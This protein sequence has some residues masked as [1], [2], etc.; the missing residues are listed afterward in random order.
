MGFQL[1][2]E[3]APVRFCGP[4]AAVMAPPL[5][6]RSPASFWKTRMALGCSGVSARHGRDRGAARESTLPARCASRQSNCRRDFCI[7]RAAIH[8]PKASCLLRQPARM[9]RREP[10]RPADLPRSVHRPYRPDWP[11]VEPSP[12]DVTPTPVTLS[13]RPPAQPASRLMLSASPTNAGRSGTRSACVLASKTRIL[14]LLNSRDEP[15]DEVADS[16]S[17]GFAD[18]LRSAAPLPLAPCTKGRSAAVRRA[19]FRCR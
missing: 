2:C 7:R 19:T 16:P 15:V 8:Q 3:L 14:A 17:G 18:D 12:R 9:L 4:S 6:L 11:E 10:V 5:K 1:N 13:V